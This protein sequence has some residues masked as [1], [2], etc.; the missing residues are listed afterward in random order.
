MKCVQF[1]RKCAH[2]PKGGL[3]EI[4]IGGLKSKKTPGIS[5]GIVGRMAGGVKAENPP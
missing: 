4:S 3:L 1:S 5:R 2:P